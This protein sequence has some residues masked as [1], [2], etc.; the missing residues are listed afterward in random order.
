MM[1]KA[2]CTCKTSKPFSE[3]GTLASSKD[4]LPKRCKACSRAAIMASKHKHYIP[5]PKVREPIEV[6]RNKAKER[7]AL[8]RAKF[9]SEFIGPVMP[10]NIKKRRNSDDWNAAHPWI[11]AASLALRRARKK[12]A[13]PKWSNS[14]FIREAYHL[15][16]LR[17]KATGFKWHVDHIYPLQ[18]PLVCGL[19]VEQNLQVIPALVNQRKHNKVIHHG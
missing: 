13:T 9:L 10:I 2:C 15:A 4:G 19:H 18:S 11:K 6:T 8:K 16:R 7:Y 12:Y 3:F 17:T 1:E 5:H 14:F